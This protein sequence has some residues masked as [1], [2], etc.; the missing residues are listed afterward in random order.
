MCVPSVF[1]YEQSSNDHS[2]RNGCRRFQLAA[3]AGSIPTR[4]ARSGFPVWWGYPVLLAGVVSS[5][6]GILYALEE[7]D[8]KRLLAYSSVENIGIIYLALGAALIFQAYDA[9]IWAAV[10]LVAALAH[11]VNHALFKSALFMGA[12]SVSTTTHTLNLDDLGGLLSRMPYTGASLLVACCS[13]AGLPLFNGFVSEWLIFRS[14]LAGATLSSRLPQIVLPLCAGSLALVGGLSAACFMGFFGTAFL[15]RPRHIGAESAV[16]AP[17]TM[18]LAL[19]VLA[20]ACLAI[21]VYPAVLLRPLSLVANSLVANNSAPLE[22]SLLPRV[23]PVL[24]I[25][26]A[27]ALLLGT[28]LR[29]AT[30][31]TGIWAC[32]LPKLSPRMEYTATAFSKPLRS[33]FAV[34]YRPHRTIEVL[35][36]DQPYFPVAVSYRSVRTTSFEESLYRPVVDAIVAAA[37]Q[38]RR[39]H[40]GNVQ[41]YLLYIFLTL[42]SLLALVKVLR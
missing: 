8:I 4:P 18:G 5:V 21:G 24:T 12:G 31:V 40:T 22:L 20:L 35:P 9:S 19:S 7:R 29:R 2:G 11:T 32:G 6:L 14:F 42:V 39:L 15:G 28:A 16:E 17:W 25:C 27:G 3:C 38:V 33:V 37:N 26:V 30:R 23:L 34:V 13:I 10:A 1:L 36:A 41:M